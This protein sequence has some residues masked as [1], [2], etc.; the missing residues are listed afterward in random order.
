[1]TVRKI[2]HFYLYSFTPQKY[3]IGTLLM[4]LF[5]SSF[6]VTRSVAAEKN[7]HELDARFI[8]TIK[9]EEEVGSGKIQEKGFCTIQVSGKIAKYQEDEEEDN[10]E[11]LVYRPKGMNASYKYNN[12]WHNIDP[13]DECY[14]LVAEENAFGSVEIKSVDEA[15]GPSDGMFELQAFLGYGGQIY[16][17]QWLAQVSPEKMM[18]IDKQP[19]NDNYTFKLFV[20][21]KTKIQARED[22]FNTEPSL[23]RTFL[24][25]LF[26]DE[27]GTTGMS[28]AFD[29]SATAQ[30][31]QQ[32]GYGNCCGVTRYT[33]SEGSNNTK[34]T[35]SWTFGKVAT[36]QILHWDKDTKKWINV[37]NE[38][39][40]VITGEQVKLKAR[41]LPE[42]EGPLTKGQWTID[43]GDNENGKFIKKY[44]ADFRKGEVLRLDAKELQQPE[45]IFYWTDEG[46]AK[47]TYEAMANNRPLTA[48]TEFNIREPQYKVT[49]AAAEA[50]SIKE[51]DKFIP[52]NK[53]KCWVAGGTD[54]PG[55]T[56][57]VYDGIT[58][59]PE[60][61][62]GIEGE[63][64]W[65][66][67]LESDVFYWIYRGGAKEKCRL[68]EVLDRCYPYPTQG[69]VAKD[70]PGLHIGTDGKPILKENTNAPLVQAGKTQKNRMYLMFKP[71]GENSQW[72][73]LKIVRWTWDG[74]CAWDD[75]KEEWK[76][77]NGKVAPEK[78]VPEDTPEYPEWEE[79]KNAGNLQVWDCWKE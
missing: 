34:S 67:I 74:Q 46:K 19:S 41:V 78:P 40:D 21:F 59:T 51:H 36:L 53:N 43:N 56:Y 23:P 72:I 71:K 66:Q 17:M 49:V 63:T 58:F 1:M 7:E 73:P 76:I 28:G 2:Q 29:H 12:K 9:W 39:V 15:T 60:P 35:V 10:S 79:G 44:D 48:E 26:I 14:G 18:D 22:C 55:G 30:T 33:P 61:L 50:S 54:I 65:V 70:T 16:M 62:D 11:F 6:L 64:Q 31:F 57:F 69:V 3:V 5:L 42:K 45:V 47:V 37:N 68:I 20:P 8:W 75:W 4:F 13:T 77:S 32:L 24:F 25:E 52:L 27:Y 38:T